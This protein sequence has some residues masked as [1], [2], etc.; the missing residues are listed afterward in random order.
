MPT[1]IAANIVALVSGPSE[2]ARPSAVRDTE[3]PVS[4]RP[5]EG[6]QGAVRN[7]EP[8]KVSR[9]ELE[10][11]VSQIQDYVQSIRRDIRFRVDEDS[12]RTIIRV[13]NSETDELIRQIPPDEILAVTQYIQESQGLLFR[14]QV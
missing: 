12:G 11:A 7:R 8:V 3:T 5:A 10:E 4:E 2:S 13:T 14:E 6:G 1:E 9:A